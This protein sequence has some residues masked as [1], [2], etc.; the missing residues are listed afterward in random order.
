MRS[1]LLV[2][3]VMCGLLLSP[4]HALADQPTDAGKPDEKAKL[5]EERLELLRQENELLKKQNE[6][7]KRETELLRKESKKESTS[8]PPGGTTPHVGVVNIWAVVKNYKKT[9][10]LRA[11]LQGIVK[12]YDDDAKHTK[13]ELETKK[14]QLKD[15]DKYTENEKAAIAKDVKRLEKVLTDKSEE[16]REVLIKKES[17]QAVAVYHEIEEAIRQMAI[18]KGMDLVSIYGDTPDEKDR[19]VAKNLARKINTGASIP[20]YVAPG[21]DLTEEVLKRLNEKYEKT[22]DTDA[23]RGTTK[24]D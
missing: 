18:S 14:L 16:M 6:L 10:E 12:A 15:N 24:K 11:E 5:L 8:K 20:V 2:T 7:L 13:N 1:F 22:S 3:A 17:E 4:F 9:Q 23:K 19:N 21:V